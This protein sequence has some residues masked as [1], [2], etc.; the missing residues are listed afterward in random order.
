MSRY[1][2]N[3][4]K[5]KWREKGTLQVLTGIKLYGNDK[6]GLIKEIIGIITDELGIN[7]K[8]FTLN[9]NNDL[10]EGEA[11]LYITSIDHLNHV[12]KQLQKV[13]GINKIYRI[14]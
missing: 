1:G 14:D 3:I 12:I 4:V 8:S 5:T 13:E 9:T 7:I 2:N 10:F 6:F 11:L